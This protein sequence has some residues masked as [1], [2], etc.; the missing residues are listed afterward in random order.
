MGKGQAYSTR[1]LYV[2]CMFSPKKTTMQNKF[3]LPA[4]GT[5][6]RIVRHFQSEGFPGITEALIVR[7]QV[8]KGS[9]G[10]IAAAFEAAASVGGAPPLQEY[11]EIQPYGFYSEIRDFSAAKQAFKA[12]FGISLRR[13]VPRIFFDK[14]PVTA[15]DALAAGTKYDALLKL[16]SN[17]D[18]YA[19]GILLNDPSSSFFEYLGDHQGNDWQKIMGDL[20]AVATSFG[21]EFESI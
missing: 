1:I 16:N 10:T 9:H 17:I 7:I 5:A 2:N 20:G 21:I 12:D 8:K 11:F 19:L 3:H 18:G 6:E 13:E 4:N 15:D 14:A